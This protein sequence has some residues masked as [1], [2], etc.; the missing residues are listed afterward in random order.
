MHYYYDVLINL[1]TNLWSFYEWEQT[2]PIIPIKKI[3]LVR[4]H[5]KDIVNFMR[6]DVLFDEEWISKFLEKTIIKNQ[7]ERVNCILFSSARHSLVLEFDSHGKVISRSRLL[8]EDENNCNEVT[9]ALKE[10]VVPYETKEKIALSSEFRQA[11]KEK[12]LIQ[13]ELD[14]LKD[15]KNTTKCSFLYYEWFGLIEHDMDKMISKMNDE[16]HKSYSLKIHEIALLIH[17]SYKERL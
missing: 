6:Y 14:T 5:N 16:L 4:V 2:D 11:F 13:V 3:P 7:K 15:T 12:R 8:L 9:Y 10:T 17:L 1:D